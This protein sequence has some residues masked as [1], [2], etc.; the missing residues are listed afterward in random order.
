V[1]L[2]PYLFIFVPLATAHYHA[3][4]IAHSHAI[5]VNHY[6]YCYCYCPVVGS[7]CVYCW[8][9]VLS[10]VI[11]L[12]LLLTTLFLVL[13][14]VVLFISFMLGYHRHLISRNLVCFVLFYCF[15]ISTFLLSCATQPLLFLITPS[16][17][18][19][20]TISDAIRLLMGLHLSLVQA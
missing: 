6:C 2:S 12:L 15:F 7:T 3:V 9:F 16:Y 1:Y 14:L 20:L 11:L 13:F 8:L 5:L 19:F 4:V 10:I 17:S 18:F